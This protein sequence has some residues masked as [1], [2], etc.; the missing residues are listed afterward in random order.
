VLGGRQGSRAG[1][2][3]DGGRAFSRP[4]WL[5]GWLKNSVDSGL[6]PEC[7]EI[8]KFGLKAYKE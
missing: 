8:Y 3:I 7:A 5:A 4:I 1:E 6:S 2:G